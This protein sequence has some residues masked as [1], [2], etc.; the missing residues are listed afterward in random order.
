M[1]Q[2]QRTALGQQIEAERVRQFGTKS[3]AYQAARINS[4]TWDRIEDGE[5]VR[6]DRLTAAVKTLWPSSGGDWLKVG[7]PTAADG[8]TT[9]QRLADLEAR[10]E[11][12]ERTHQRQESDPHGIAAA[13]TQAGGSPADEVTTEEAELLADD[14]PGVP[15]PRRVRARR[16]RPLS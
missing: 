3:A 6:D 8:R 5:L 15:S 13:I 4:T 12:L 1:T 11:Q 10:V 16:P 14:P 9:D 7:T 2:E